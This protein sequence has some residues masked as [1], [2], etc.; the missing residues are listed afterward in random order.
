MSLTSDYYSIHLCKLYSDSKLVR[1]TH[2][3]SSRYF[4]SSVE[5]SQPFHNMN[6]IVTVYGCWSGVVAAP[7]S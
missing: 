4:T 7:W 6:H 2:A 5:A 3:H 1:N